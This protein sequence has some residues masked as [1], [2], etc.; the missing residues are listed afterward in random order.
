LIEE[1]EPIAAMSDISP[2]C[3]P[4]AQQQALA[5][6]VVVSMQPM[7]ELLEDIEV[8]IAENRRWRRGDPAMDL[9]N[10][11]LAAVRDMLVIKLAEGTSRD[12]WLKVAAAA[13]LADKSADTIRYWISKD[14]VR[15]RRNAG[16]DYEV[17]RDSLYRHMDRRDRRTA[18]GASRRPRKEAA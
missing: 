13:K 16:G 11:I 17:D 15:W 4:D 2:I 7:L 14:Y 9:E 8:R 6:N 10:G 18:C 3:K 5:E 1:A 12:R